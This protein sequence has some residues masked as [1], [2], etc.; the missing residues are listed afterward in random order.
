MRSALWL[1]VACGMADAFNA[2][3][4]LAPSR[5]I[6]RGAARRSDGLLALRAQQTAPAFPD[7][8]VLTKV[9][10]RLGETLQF[11][12]ADPVRARYSTAMIA[13]FSYFLGQD[14]TVALAGINEGSPKREIVDERVS[15]AAT[16]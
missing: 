10:G 14:V 11:A 13:R 7:L 6:A 1:V 15:Q 3:T 9:A 2:P 12:A 16:H 4:A 5:R 8:S